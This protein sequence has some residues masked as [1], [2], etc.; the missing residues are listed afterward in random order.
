MK[1]LSPSDPLQVGPYDLEGILGA[2]GMGTVYLGRSPG[3]RPAAVKVINPSYLA[4][5]E[6]VARF[7]R[8][9]AMLGTVRSAYTA[10][11]ID[12]EVTTAPFWMA[13]EF[14]PG[15]TLA[16]T[17]AGE[18]ALSAQRCLGLLAAVAEGLAD[19]HRHD[20]CHRDIKPQ[21]V[22]LSPTGPQLIDFGLARGI[23]ESGL[24]VGG[25]TL[26]TPGFI[27]PELMASDEL[28]PATDVFALGA[29]VANAATGRRPYGGGTFETV[30]VR[31]MHEDIDLDGVDPGLAGLLRACTAKD[32]SARPTPAEIVAR[33]RSL[34]SP[35]A[36]PPVAAA[37][38][39]ATPATATAEAAAPGATNPAAAPPAV[40]ATPPP[41]V[42]LH[43]VPVRRRRTVLTAAALVVA[44]AL[45]F[46]GGAFAALRLAPSAFPMAATAATSPA[47]P[48]APSPSYSAPVRPSPSRTAVSPSRS[49]SPKP[50]KSPKQSPSPSPSTV[51]PVTTPTTGDG[52]CIV[53]P[54]DVTNGVKISVAKCTG[55]ANQKW[56]F[57]KEGALMNAAGTKCLDLGANGG[58]DIGNQ[59]QIWD[60]NFSGAQLWVPQP[61]ST[62]FNTGSGR[63]LGVLPQGSG[64]PA[65]SAKVCTSTALNRWQLPVSR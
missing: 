38:R 13:T 59:V 18:G 48:P 65:L 7:R 61:D 21:N 5:P 31:L 16:A 11:L 49:R 54:A 57:T 43:D 45:V 8:E 4:D 9:A 44:G 15:P 62:L 32:P 24:T 42:T 63:C 10:T 52:R 6:A 53:M 50:S 30:Y 51:K 64:G 36:P 26:G 39:A 27:A 35:G 14:I 47:L 17:I 20:I 33:C 19:I 41:A 2:G 60:C 58:A 25:I 12:A 46:A 34:R 55:A 37:P 22:I 29:T 28:S 56:T 40:P 3:G 23:D 1:P